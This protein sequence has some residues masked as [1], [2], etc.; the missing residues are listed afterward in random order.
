MEGIVGQVATEVDG[1]AVGLVGR[2]VGADALAVPAGDGDQTAL[3][4]AA[5]GAAVVEIGGEIDAGRGALA[6]RQA[7]FALG[8]GH[9]VL[10][11]EPDPR[12]QPRDGDRGEETERLPPGRGGR[13]GARERIERVL[14]HCT[15]HFTHGA[16]DMTR[17]EPS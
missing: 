8:R 14:D 7:R 9:V 2:A 13:D 15:L 5:T 17:L 16:T 12:T 11:G 3:A 1:A 6:E 4:D 10:G